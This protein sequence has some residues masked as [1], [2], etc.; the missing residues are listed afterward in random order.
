[1]FYN[2][3]RRAKRAKRAERRKGGIPYYIY[4]EGGGGDYGVDGE[5]GGI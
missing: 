4:K 5:F 1:M 3:K 2:I